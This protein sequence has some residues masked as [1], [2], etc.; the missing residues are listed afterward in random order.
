MIE[1]V[2]AVLAAVVVVGLTAS[3]LGYR[4]SL[5]RRNGSPEWYF[6]A[7]KV[8]YSIGFGFLLLLWA[9]GWGL[10]RLQDPAAALAM[11]NDPVAGYANTFGMGVV[12]IGV[13]CSLKARQLLIPPAERK[14]W[15]WVI[16]WM[17]PRHLWSARR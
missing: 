7:A 16:A 13:Y 3:A 17:H 1:W 2:N 11:L 12:L 14:K 15:P 9:T 4:H 8:L 5:T 6:A 10:L